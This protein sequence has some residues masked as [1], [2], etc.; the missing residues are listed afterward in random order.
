MSRIFQ[1]KYNIGHIY[2][3]PCVQ[4]N[5]VY[6]LSV[7]LYVEIEPETVASTEL[8]Q[9]IQF[10]HHTTPFVG[11]CTHIMIRTAAVKPTCVRLSS[12][13]TD[14]GGVGVRP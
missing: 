7:F 3:F 14:N 1:D 2:W 8:S 13:Y 5:Y 4:K 12:N 6:V 10:L 11:F 9:P